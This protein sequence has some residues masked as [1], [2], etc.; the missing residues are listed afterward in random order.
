[1]RWRLIIEEYGPELCYIK[2]THNVTADALSRL[3]T[4]DNVVTTQQLAELF[5]LDDVPESSFLLTYGTLYAHQQ[6]DEPLLTKLLCS[7]VYQLRSFRGGDRPYQ[8]ICWSGKIVVPSTLQQH[9]VDWYH[10]TLCHPGINRTE[11][12]IRQ[13]FTWKHLTKQ[14]ATT[15]QTCRKC[16]ITKKH[17]KK[18][19]LLPAKKAEEEAN[20]WE[21][22]CV[23]LIGP[24]QIIKKI[25][26]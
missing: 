25:K 6:A 15:C 14:V 2:G 26:G 8:L 19:G 11:A 12:T 18:Y 13:H 4:S 24:Y 16:Q 22:L 3:P 5:A 9:V 10:T 20:L 7:K 1:M 17:T 21:K 23:D